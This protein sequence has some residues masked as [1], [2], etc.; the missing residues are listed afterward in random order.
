MSRNTHAANFEAIIAGIMLTAAFVG[1][2]IFTV[3]TAAEGNAAMFFI[4]DNPGRWFDTGIDVEGTR[5]LAVI[6][7]GDQV[8]FKGK[9]STVHTVTSLVFPTSAAGMPFDTSAKKVSA[10]VRLQTP[11]LYVFTCKIHPYMFGAVIVDDPATTGLDLAENVTLVNGLEVPTSSDL[12]TRLLRT[13]FI[14]TNPSNW[15]DYTSPLSWHVT[16]PDVDVRITG[17]LVVNLP[18]TLDARYGNDI[19]LASLNNPPT[20]GVGKVWVDTQFELTS[21]KTKPGTATA[22]DASNWQVA[23]KVALPQINMNN[24]HNMWTD[25]GQNLIYQT[26][27]FGNKLTVFDG[28]TGKF[29]RNITVG[30]APSHVMTRVDTDQVH[31]AING[32]NSTE[33]VVELSPLAK[34]VERKIDIGRSHPHAHWMGHDGQ[35]MVTPNAFTADTTQFNFGTDS[36]TAIL[37]AGV[38]P[39][40]TGMMPDS[41]KYYVASLLD[42][43]VSVIDMSANVVTK[44]INLLANY[45]PISGAVGGDGNVGALPIQTPV[46]PN[47]KYM[48]TAN[49]LTATITITDTTSD[50]LTKTLLCDPG[51]HGVQF[52]AKLGGG[53]YVYVSSKFSNELI[54]VD[55][56]P[57]NDGNAADAYIAG[58]IALVAL[59]GTAKDASIIGNAGMGGQGILPI[60]VV[61]NGWVQNLPQSW[62]DQLTSEQR[63]PFP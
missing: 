33:S 49:T 32:S 31:V 6:A 17:G 23:R 1:T 19:P 12:A 61:Y 9:S 15:Q 13:F 26:Q 39:I 8:A 14:A 21:G 60:P 22:V 18:D 2:S 56:D 38:L 4:T 5:S 7:P 41:S 52:G 42:S 44:T 51:C 3:A 11:G 57:N 62:K 30:P 53:Y 55:V 63:N 24:P 10:T 34:G 46:S 40:A 28:S 20:P 36:V 25:R 16:Y 54:V 48:V 37:P 58:R 50:M 35:T 29:I 45:D 43:T 47:G 27:W 59:G